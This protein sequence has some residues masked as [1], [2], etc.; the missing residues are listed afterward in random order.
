MSTQSGVALRGR[1]DVVCLDADGNEKWRDHAYNAITDTAVTALLDCF[2]RNQ[3]PPAQPYMGLIDN[4]GFS[5]NPTTD[6]YLSHGGWV[7]YTSYSQSNRPNWTTVAASS[8][9]ITNTSAVVF[10]ITGSS[11]VLKG[12]FITYGTSANEKAFTAGA[13][14]TLCSTAAFS[15]G[16]QSVNNGDT[17]NVTYT[18]S[19]SST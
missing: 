11:G 14:K 7:E 12:L 9:S 4:A 10:S 6:T 16:N 3:T 15:G 1:Y 5:N 17:L 13:G 2:F 19:G 18:V 8:K